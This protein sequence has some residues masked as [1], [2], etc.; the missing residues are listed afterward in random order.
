MLALNS[1][2]GGEIDLRQAATSISLLPDF[3]FNDT[4]W[5]LFLVDGFLTGVHAC[6]YLAL[7]QRACHIEITSF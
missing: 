1:W 4:S 5:D 7:V 6:R 3:G 2:S